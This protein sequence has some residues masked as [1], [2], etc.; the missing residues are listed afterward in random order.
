MAGIVESNETLTHACTHARTKASDHTP[1]TPTPFLTLE[2]RIVIISSPVIAVGKANWKRQ[3]S[4]DKQ[5]E[6]PPVCTAFRKVR[7][8]SAFGGIATAAVA[9]GCQL[10]NT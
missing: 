3:R 2:S 6:E 10:A 9:A 1:V 7:D 5:E 8:G 4:L